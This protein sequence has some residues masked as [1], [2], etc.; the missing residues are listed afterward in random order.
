[1]RQVGL[2]NRYLL[3]GLAFKAVVIGG[4]YATGRELVEFFLPAGPAGGFHGML[5]AM[6]LWSAV[7]AVTYLFAFRV[8][9]TDYRSFFR[10][11]LGP[12][13]FLFEIIYFGFLI[14]VLSVFGS[15]AGALGASLFGFP[16]IVGT[17]ALIA[18]VLVVV[19]LGQAAAEAV[20]KYVS[21]LLYG[22]YAIF[23]VLCLWSFGSRILDGFALDVPTTGW[24]TGGITY[25]SYNV[26]GA[27]L[28][29]PVLRHLQSGRDA[30]IAGVLSGPL[31]MIPAFAFFICL[32]P[33]YP[34]IL[35][36]PLPSDYV[37]KALGIPFFHFTFQ[38]MVFFALLECSVG[39]VQAFMARID[40]HNEQRGRTTPTYLRIAVPAVITLGSVF[41]AAN[42]GLVSLI[43]EGYRMMA[44]AILAIFILPL[45]TIGIFRMLRHRRDTA[46]IA[47]QAA[48]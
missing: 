30:V 37:L 21:V 4:G 8:G 16:D 34:G 18:L 19:A 41:I 28:I 24:A 20:F 22:V 1:M 36:E 29:L 38:T 47:D 12:F 27:V 31:A 35:H 9:A 32:T 17:L 46:P 5:L 40:T 44:Y 3:P 14:L 13:D 45:L 6:V 48:A 2:L 26:I 25:A 15:A 11:L 23:L 42:I 7:C 10:N 39:F 33:F 43:A